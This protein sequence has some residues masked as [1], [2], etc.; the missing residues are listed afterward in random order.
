M[1][2][3]R[4]LVFSPTGKQLA[5]LSVDF[6]RE[7]KINAYGKGSFTIALNDTKFKKQYLN[8]GNFIYVE[9]SELPPWVGTIEPPGKWSNYSLEVNCLSAEY[10]LSKAVTRPN[11]KIK[12]SPGKIF[13]QLIEDVGSRL[14]LSP[15][16]GKIYDSGKESIY[17]KPFTSIYD[18]ALD[19]KENGNEEF[20][21]TPLI[22]NGRL[23]LVANWYKAMG[24]TKLRKLF[25]TRNFEMGGELLE[26]GEI[27]NSAFIYGDGATWESKPISDAIDQTSAFNHGYSEVGEY[28]KTATDANVSDLAQIYVKKYKEP[29][30]TFKIA[31][32]KEDDNDTIFK[33]IKLGDTFP[34]STVSCGWTGSH[35]GLDSKFR[36]LQMTFKDTEGKL[37]ITADEVI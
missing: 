9:N 21:V 7:W 28:D 12:G 26:Q 33:D 27:I 18:A 34:F 1:N 30:R 37:N 25:E 5:E 13:Q 20:N 24:T 32:A 6:Y 35:V 16:V 11:E 22:E 15:T 31:V 2:Y 4:P 3:S 10:Y 36:V 14:S 23:I 8:Y 17:N 19:L 29:R